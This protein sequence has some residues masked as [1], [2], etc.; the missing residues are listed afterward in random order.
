MCRLACTH[1]ALQRNPVRDATPI[2]T[3]PHRKPRSLTITEIRQLR[4]MLTNDHTAIR[5]DLPDFIDMMLATGLRIG[6]TASI[7]WSSVDLTNGTIDVGTGI[8][9]RTTGIGCRSA[10]MIRPNSPPAP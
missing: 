6:E 1:D 10:P 4:A 5:S 8:V 7:Q 9:V 3:K 2:T